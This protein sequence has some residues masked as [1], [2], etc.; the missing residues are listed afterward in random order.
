MT[1]RLRI[2]HLGKFYP[3]EYGGIE[4]VTEALAED[5]AAQGNDV[6]VI[7]FRR[8]EYKT[9]CSS[10]GPKIR[11][12]KMRGFVASQ[13]L[14]LGYVLDGLRSVC[15]A[16][17]AHIHT[18]NLLGSLVAILTPRRVKVVLHWHADIENK[19][20]LGRLVY[21]IE[22]LALRRADAV[23]C[24]SEPYLMASASLRFWRDKTRI[25]PI[26]ISHVDVQIGECS[27][28]SPFVLF[29]GRLVPYKGLS[30]LI[31]ASTKM[32]SD[33]P[34]VVVGSGPLLADLKAQARLMG[35]ESRIEFHGRVDDTTLMS[36][37]ANAS[38]FC[39]PSINR[40]EAFGVVLLEAMRAGCPVV[41]SDI[42][43]SGVSWV[44]KAGLSFPVG[45]S[46]EL[47]RQLDEVLGSAVLRKSLSKNARGRF[48]AFFTRRLMSQRFM[49]LYQ[50]LLS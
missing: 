44:N 10:T 16:D 24:T 13:P 32:R 12:Y 15:K 25:I 40:L 33:A 7:C 1:D 29:V 11:R 50:E 36:L 23:V 30:V 39:L 2:V 9:L 38:V 37:F 22:Q 27:G 19:G 46:T 35:V 6:K 31:E 34:I 48:T 21:P 4:S 3:P 5:H 49:I 42:P 14:S 26:G 43:G 28:S 47:A 20:I 18:P 17:I 45:D 41:A 8:S